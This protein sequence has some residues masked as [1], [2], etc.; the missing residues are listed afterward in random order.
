[1]KAIAIDFDGCLCADAYPEI[2]APN[3]EVIAKA[4][5]EQEAGAG[6]ILWTCR[7]GQRL[8]EA[9]EAC[10]GWGL[11]FDAVNESLPSWIEAFGTAPRKVGATEYWDDK[12]VHMPPVY[13][14]SNDPLTIEQLREMNRFSPPIWDEC[15]HEWCAVRPNGCDGQ[16]RIS[17]IGGGCRPLES[18]RF[19]RR[20]PEGEEDA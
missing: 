20:P 18:G 2:G 12:S 3:W 7:E 11:H 19:Y 14:P 10:E 9:V 8:Q 15:L 6:L 5:Q 4:K 13:Q 16:Q 1:M 17:Y